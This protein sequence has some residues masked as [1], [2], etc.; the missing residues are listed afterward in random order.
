MILWIY[1][2]YFSNYLF[3]MLKV[4]FFCRDKCKLCIIFHM[5]LLQGAKKMLQ[6]HVFVLQYLFPEKH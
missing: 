2:N 3:F 6:D 5:F 1:F 4:L